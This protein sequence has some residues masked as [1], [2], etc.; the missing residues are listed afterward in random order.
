MGRLRRTPF[1]GRGSLMLKIPEGGL[2]DDFVVL[3]VNS[4]RGRV[5]DEADDA[6]GEE[7]SSMSSSRPTRRA[8]EGW[9]PRANVLLRPTI[10]AVDC[11]HFPFSGCSPYPSVRCA[12]GSAA[13]GCPCSGHLSERRSVGQDVPHLGPHG[14]TPVCDVHTGLHDE[15][16][17]ECF[18]STYLHS[19]FSIRCA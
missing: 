9:T 19:H 5:S 13:G 10:R 8:A 14:C 4:F 15:G 17:D 3:R 16:Q 6:E 12:H 11:W 2:G 18:L 7:T 1:G